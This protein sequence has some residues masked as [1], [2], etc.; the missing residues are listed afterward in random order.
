MKNL[1]FFDKLFSKP[2]KQEI[3]TSGKNPE[4]FDFIKER[5]LLKDYLPHR[6]KRNSAE[7]FTALYFI[8][9]YYKFRNLD[10]KYLDKCIEYCYICIACLDSPDMKRDISDGI[11]IPAFKRLIIIYENKKDYEKAI[12]TARLAL[13]YTNVNNQEDA[14]YYAKKMSSNMKKIFNERSETLKK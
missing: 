11:F 2:K 5:L 14:E 9:F 6:G 12:E 7:Y 1:G 10:E 3:R 13:T 8:D 4:G